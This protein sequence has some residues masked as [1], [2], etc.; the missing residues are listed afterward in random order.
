MNGLPLLEIT[1]A[2]AGLAAELVDG[3]G[4]P[5][6][7]KVDAL[8][9]AIAAGNGMDYLLTWNCTHIANAALRGKIES[10]CRA[11]GFEPP[12]ICTPLELM[13]D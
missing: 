12:T 4:L 10:I 11:C 1:D 8:H 5:A 7:A 9:V 6:K 13:Q 2:A 3:G